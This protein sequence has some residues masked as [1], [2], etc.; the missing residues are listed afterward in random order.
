MTTTEKGRKL[1]R[2][3]EEL[4]AVASIRLKDTF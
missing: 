2:E 4:E 3:F 1:N